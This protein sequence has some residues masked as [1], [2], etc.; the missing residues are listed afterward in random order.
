MNNGQK[1]KYMELCLAV[2]REEVEYAELYK[3]KEPDYDEDFDAWCVYTRSHRNPNKALITDN[4]RNVAR[5][6]FILAKE[7]NVSGFFRE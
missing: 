5:T 4:L 3:E 7:I 2:A 6:A 1:I